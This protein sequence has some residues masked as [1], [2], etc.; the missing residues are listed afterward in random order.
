MVSKFTGYKAS[1]GKTFDSERE[2]WGEEL[3]LLVAPHIDNDAIA[4]KLVA[5]VMQAPGELYTI[6]QNLVVL[7]PV[8]RAAAEHEAPPAPHLHIWTVDGVVESRC[9]VC[10]EARA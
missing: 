9:V 1:N 6:L 2:A 7:S 10:G 8:D 3:V 4:R 5:G